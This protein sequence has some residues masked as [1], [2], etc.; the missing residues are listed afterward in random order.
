MK[1]K[2]LIIGLLAVLCAFTS[3]ENKKQKPA[4]E[5]PEVD[6][7]GYRPTEIRLT[8]NFDKVISLDTNVGDVYIFGQLKSGG[9]TGYTTDSS[10]SEYESF[11][12]IPQENESVMTS[13]LLPF[14]QK[15][16][17][18]Y[19]DGENFLYVY[20]KDGLQLQ[21]IGLGSIT[22]SPEVRVSVLP[23]GRNNYIINVDNK[24][25]IIADKTGYLSDISTDGNITGF[26]RGAENT[27]NCLI[28]DGSSE[29]I[30]GIDIDSATLTD[31]KKIV[32]DSSAY[33]S[34][35]SEKYSCISVMDGGI[36]GISD[37]T[38]KK[39]TDFANMNFKPSEVSGIIETSDGNYAVNVG[40]TVYFVTEDNIKEVSAKKIIWLGAYQYYI[41]SRIERYVN[42][43]NE[44]QDEYEIK[45]R[46]Y[47]GQD[48]D[49]LYKDVISG[50]APD[51][52]P[53]NLGTPLASYGKNDVLFADLYPFLDNDPDL[54][55]DDF[56]PNILTGLERDG[57]L[58][59]IGT[60]FTLST[61]TVS[62]DDGI[63][64]NWTIDDMIRIYENPP[65]NKT[66][67]PILNMDKIRL[68]I[69]TNYFDESMYIDYNNAEC[70]F[71][72]P[73]FIKAL[74]FFQNN[75]IGLTYAEY[76]ELSRQEL[77]MIPEEEIAI[78]SIL[79]TYPTSINNAEMLFDNA[80]INDSETWAGYVG[81]GTKS[82][83]HINMDIMY[84]ISATSPHTDGAWEFL[85]TIFSDYTSTFK[86][87]G[88]T[89]M[90]SVD[91]PVIEKYFDESLEAFTHD[92]VYVD[93]ETGKTVVEKRK[94]FDG[95]EVENFTPEEVQYYKDKITSA[96][97]VPDDINISTMVWD[98]LNDYFENDGSAK[99]TAENIQKK[100]S[101]YLNE[102]YT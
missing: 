2:K 74:E 29:F 85:K 93:Y 69:F 42:L 57:K 51:I 13:A 92:N 73:D 44:S 17:L 58:Y 16:V 97:I 59:Q 78:S 22:D 46:T 94:T 89:Y 18:T 6:V 62:K 48:P 5:V 19:L 72:S 30:A 67:F 98:E 10:F 43:F 12:F 41:P 11:S 38:V 99:K 75:K 64:E 31:K 56:L 76:D 88:S 1:G 66:L 90:F 23:Y 68:H 61:V 9:Y 96:S 77:F 35:M 100:V 21:S 71:D 25:L 60:E 83:T 45:V 70:H 91:F 37:S 87:N 53:F 33:A 8:D 63:P 55:R 82:G 20:G 79:S 36:Y 14:G 15:A 84:G 49:A 102:R 26:S 28:S 24:R 40:G 34:C 52:I 7:M 47:K 80:R 54:S 50:N 95:K 3:C 4:P 86:E 27:V 81:D 32:T 65:E 101:E 39:I